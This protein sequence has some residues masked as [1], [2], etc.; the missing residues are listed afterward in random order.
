MEYRPKALSE[1]ED[2]NVNV[3][4]RSPLRDVLVM[5]GGALAILVVLYWILGFA[6][7]L[8][9]PYIPLHV[10]K[11]MGRLFA[12]NLCENED[13]SES[14]RLQEMLDRLQ[15]G[16]E[17][18]DRRCPRGCPCSRPWPSSSRA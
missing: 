11:Q 14:A 16:L 2:T 8:L 17:E 13:P 4:R 1:N 9:S 10:E 12:L 18:E 15:P 3:T 7:D 6:V 5:L